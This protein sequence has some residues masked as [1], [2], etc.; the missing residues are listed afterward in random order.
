MRPTLPTVSNRAHRSV[1]GQR[2][3]KVAKEVEFQLLGAN[4]D[5]LGF[6]GFTDR[7]RYLYLPSSLA[8]M[9]KVPGMGNV[10]SPLQRGGG[11]SRPCGPTVVVLTS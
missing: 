11:S 1:V 4:H 3:I 5:R 10:T 9:T 6:V 8:E 7:K 2:E